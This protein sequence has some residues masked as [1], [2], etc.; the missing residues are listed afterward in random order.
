MDF[1]VRH[2]P[3]QHKDLRQPGRFFCRKSIRHKDLRRYLS[4]N[5][6]VLKTNRRHPS[7]VPPVV[8]KY[9]RHFS[10]KD[11]NNTDTKIRAIK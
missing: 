11:E 10:P 4:V 5:V 9:Y 8:S 1:A 2:K 7:R 3:L 6:C